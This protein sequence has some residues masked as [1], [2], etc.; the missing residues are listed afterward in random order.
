MTRPPAPRLEKRRTADF[1]RELSERASSW[2]PSWSQDQRAPDF[3]LA[4]LK[5]AARFSSEVAE[6]LDGVGDKMALGF[7]DWLGMKSEAARPAR[8]P[9][10]FKL[11][12]TA[13]NPVT[14]QH[15]V[16]M[17]ADVAEATV[18]FETEADLCIVP[19]TIAVVVG[20]DPAKDEYYL[21]PPGLT[22]L[23]PADPLPTEWRLKNFAAADSSM[24]QLD[25]GLGLSAGLFVEIAGAQYE[26]RAAKD[27][28]ATIEPK[29]P[30][31]GFEDGALV[32]KV[33]TFRPFDGARN[34][35]EHILYIGDPD[36]L[37]V[38]AA[39]SIELI[40]LPALIDGVTWEYWGK[41]ETAG[42]DDADARWLEIT[43]N[44]SSTGSM[45]L[46]KPRGAVEPVQIGA[47]QSRW[48]RA[49][50]TMSQAMTLADAVE[51]RI[52]PLTSGDKTPKAIEESDWDKLL[53]PEVFVNSTSSPPSDFYPLGREPRMFDTLYLGSNEAFSK[54]DA[55]AWVQFDLADAV[56][57]SLSGINTAAFGFVLAAIDARGTLHLLKRS[58][59]GALARFREPIQPADG[60]AL[61]KD[62]APVLW[63]IGTTLHVAVATSDQVHVWSE[64]SPDS[65]A[66]KWLE[67]GAPPF[68]TLETAPIAG[69]ALVDWGG[70]RL[71]AL[72]DGRL[73]SR[74]VN[75]T[76][77]VW[78]GKNV[79]TSPG[80]P[81]DIDAIFPVRHVDLAKVPTRVLARAAARLYDII[82]SATVAKLLSGVASDVRPAAL[83]TAGN[84]EVVAVNSG[85]TQ[86]I[87]KQASPAGQSTILSPHFNSKEAINVGAVIS[88]RIEDGHLTAYLA[89][90][91]QTA[92][93]QSL[94]AWQPFVT[95][96]ENILFRRQ[97]G[98]GVGALRGTSVLAEVPLPGMDAY[99]F[100]TGSLRGEVY[101]AR[102]GER[103]L[104]IAQQPDLRSALAI[105]PPS[106]AVVAGDMI[107]FVSGGQLKLG[108]IKS[109]SARGT[110]SYGNT[111]FFWVS[112][113]LDRDSDTTTFQYFQTSSVPNGTAQVGSTP[114][115]LQFAGALNPVADWL[116][117]RAQG[118]TGDPTPVAVTAFDPLTFIATIAPAVA[119]AVANVEYWG[120]SDLSGA[121]YPALAL[122]AVS[123]GSWTVDAL[124]DGDLYFPGMD[125]DRQPVIAYEADALQQHPLHLVFGSRWQTP[126]PPQIAFAVDSGVR[127]WAQVLGDSSANPALSWEYWDGTSWLH[128]AVDPAQ[129]ETNSL[130]NSG[131]IKFTVP[132]DLKPVE[133]A[134]KTSHWIRARLIGGDYGR[135]NVV[136]I[137]EPVPNTTPPQTKQTVQRTTEGIQP[138]YALN[139]GI[140]YTI[141]K[142]TAP[143]FLLTQDSGMLRDQS[144]ANRT[145][146]AVI[147]VFTPL[148]VTLGHLDGLGVPSAAQGGGAADNCVPDCDCAGGTPS[149]SP[150]QS[151]QSPANGTSA[152][153]ATSSSAQPALYLG[154]NS[155][156]IGAPVNMLFAVDREG[157][158]DRMAPLRIDALVG[159]RFVPLVASDKTRALGETGL[160]EMAFPIEPT[161]KGLFGQRPLT[162]LRITPSVITGEWKPSLSGVYLNAVWA[163][164]AET[165]TREL[166][167]A[168]SGEPYLTLSL[169]RPPLLQDSLELRVREPLGEEERSAL[170]RE[171]PDGV[172]Y[173]IDD[174]PGD[175]VLWRQV[176]DPVDCAPMD[177]V[178]ALDEATGTI[179]FGD[180][181]QGM[182][183]PIGPDAIVAFRYKRADASTDGKVP[184]NFLKARSELNLVTSVESVETVRA[185]DHSAG[186]V[187][188]ES[189]ER[190]LRFA[191]A[192]LRH[193]GRAVT[194]SDFESL[195]LEHSA[196]V[197]QARC[198]ARSGRL[199]LVV[200]MRGKDPAPSHAQQ[201][202]L[203]RMLLEV[204][205]PALAAPRGLTIVGPAVRRM[206]V[207][208]RLAVV[209]LDVAG[210][211]ADEV[212]R[213][214]AA[215]FDTEQGG[216][217]R[218]GWPLGLAPREE[219]IA[220]ALLDIRALESI[221]AINL[222]E[223]DSEGRELLWP[224]TLRAHE[225][226]ML[227][228]DGVR[229]SFE[230]MEEAL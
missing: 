214:I 157:A 193:R 46:A 112:P 148:S 159:N 230:M 126:P 119:A 67:Y 85:H 45:L 66:S 99:L 173:G 138:P 171:D 135:E 53:R 212:T 34:R 118:T 152:S 95:G 133:W 202:E 174:L 62:I 226:A 128:L 169:A 111:Q 36:L 206:R 204:A 131:T 163:R 107:G 43:P 164:A 103:K 225:L 129:D 39:G 170:L 209:T 18:T 155:K 161:K 207:D 136:V 88:G 125:P 224:A 114:D 86:L 25:P 29:I 49:R 197:V 42:A 127:A 27:D 64:T 201:R 71:A 20:V 140:A 179:R 24:V 8:V 220:Q 151:N 145:P 32:R 16:K 70:A 156:L 172:K 7:L 154:L 228:A 185:A 52:N 203:R 195:V 199:R 205:P 223:I 104:A 2:L 81:M 57:Q 105:S 219:D 48:L 22:S 47:V 146:G 77:A 28:L 60:V 165:M 92:A 124:K 41:K 215:F 10:A 54:G 44:P 150:A 65:S 160:L 227:A 175:W 30:T 94:I 31:G 142:P 108:T 141:D 176:S 162:W 13:P 188:T 153:E 229:T 187:P 97:T 78:V 26:V 3:G 211:V 190:V 116:L 218:D 216:E 19:G 9:V 101:A 69:L 168:S 82:Q 120:P 213:R 89:V 121:I 21:P 6:R 93:G 189:P 79:E 221:A 147:E 113:W 84:L 143:K 180:G 35:Q 158:Y 38:E 58:V 96:R 186:G 23:D 210:D 75:P 55:T 182:I 208:L 177:R 137:T 217:V 40:G 80:M 200:V 63:E 87:A 183:P 191:P 110:D 166:V 196:E 109:G 5:V 76:A 184:A 198:T 68:A 59:S 167:G 181:R 115:K 33:T 61:I 74:S 1:E 83:E 73:A 14:A 12:E 37:D 102:L 122:N 178:Y 90:R 4:L 50:R 130:R 194:A 149:Q 222:V 98:P 15:P 51:L 117:I 100:L 144:D 56:F 192:R 72:R 134:G 139:V 11:A 132:T 17:Q 123:G 91:D 106:S